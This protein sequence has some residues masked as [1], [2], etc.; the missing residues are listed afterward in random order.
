ME[1]TIDRNEM[2]DTTT[3]PTGIRKLMRTHFMLINS[4][5]LRNGLILQ[6]P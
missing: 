1:I 2:R 5:S 6:K 4:A 3:D